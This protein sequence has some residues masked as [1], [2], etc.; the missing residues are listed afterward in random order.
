M[1]RSRFILIGLIA[2]AG[3]ALAAGYFLF[4]LS[5]TGSGETP[6]A[7]DFFSA[8]FP[9]GS[10][11]PAKNGAAGPGT[12]E[13][14]ATKVTE[15]IRQ[16]SA[17]PTAGAWFRSGATSTPSGIRFMERA[18]GHIFE[19]PVDSYAETRLSNTTIPLTQELIPISDT[20]FIL[21]SVADGD[22]I[23][24]SFGVL[25]ATSSQQSVNATPLKSFE[26]VAVAGDGLSVLTV[27][28]IAGGSEIELAK[29]DGTASRIILLSPL[30]SWVPLA[31]GKRFF[32]ES[33]PSS[34]IPG[35]L[36]E[37][38]ANG[39]LISLLREIPGLLSV[40]SPTGRYVLYSSGQGN[41]VTLAMLDTETGQRYPSPLRTLASKCAWISEDTPLV[42]C[43][44]SDSL[45]AGAALL[46][47]DWLLGKVALND[48]AW[49]IR[50][51][52]SSAQSLGYL[53]EITG[54]RFDIMNVR[55][56]PDGRYAIFNNKNDLTL[57]ALDLTRTE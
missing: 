56:S 26:R 27:N 19:T 28:E 48:S 33:A 47:D 45:E 2:L 50:P 32:L 55:V 38:Q 53:E 23:L 17:R 16:V 5:K 9:F 25:N 44:V 37:I 18:T 46:P 54:S 3:T 22:R 1:T 11:S 12:G 34:G 24:N 40:P 10:G 52:E 14:P 29:P 36:Y 43:G 42:F 35:F 41:L 39:S 13:Q 20:A 6:G 51:T 4:S 49:I 8:F 57:W 21:R 15:R 31:G 7:R 30:N